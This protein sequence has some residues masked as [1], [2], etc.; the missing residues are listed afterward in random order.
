M[1]LP[2]PH[3]SMMMADHGADVIR[4]EPPGEGEPSRHI[5]FMDNGESVY[6]RNTHRG[7]RSLSLNLKISAAKSVLYK[8]VENA[9]VF[10]ESFRPGVMQRLELDYS[11][12]SSINP[13]L[14]YCSISAFGQTGPLSSRVAH[15]IAVEAQAGVASLTV[16]QDGKPAMPAIAMADMSVSLMSLSAILMALYRARDTGHGDFIDMA[17]QDTLLAWMP[18]TTGRV[19]ADGEPPI[20]SEERTWGGNAMYG[21]YETADQRWLALGGAELKFAENLFTDLGRP[22]LIE[23]CKQPPGK[24]QNPARAFLKEAFLKRTLAE[25][26]LW[27]DGKDIG[28]APVNNL[29]EGFDH[30]HVQA[31]EMLLHDDNGSEHIG[32]PIKFKNEPGT[33]NLNSPAYGEHNIEIC[34]QIGLSDSEIETLKTQKAFG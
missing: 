24:P 18:N 11:K 8:L 9:D 2:G 27:F 33:A 20:P 14:V 34:K 12:L 10:I 23:V 7:K 5:G 15:D 16:G 29:R 32:V 22:D 25:W 17:M 19:F 30:P 26:M 1:F 31:R 28:Y 3:L 13:K 4:V 6:F 21:L